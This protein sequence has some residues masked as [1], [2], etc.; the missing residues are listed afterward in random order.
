[1]IY[2]KNCPTCNKEIFFKTKRNLNVSIKN[3]RD[4][5]SCAQKKSSGGEKNGMFGKKHNK[6]TIAIIKEK[7]KLQTCSEETRDKMSISAKK[8]LE[9]Y[10]YW[11]GKKHREESKNKMRIVASRRINNNNWHPSYNI[12]ACNIIEK[13]GNENGYK[14]QHAMNGGEYF[15]GNLGFWLDGYDKEKNIGIEYYEN[16]HKYTINE[17]YNRIK[18]IEEELNCK[19]IILKE[20]E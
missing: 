3:N 16:A 4:C 7:R 14:F 19:I 15:I 12:T 18:K 20:W 13:Y 9:E 1:M 2:K 11:L 5:Y 17:D 6:T 8:R 10:N